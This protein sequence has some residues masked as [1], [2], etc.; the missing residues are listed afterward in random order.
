MKKAILFVL[1]AAMFFLIGYSQ[2]IKTIE[3]KVMIEASDEIVIKTGKSSLIMKKDGTI[4]ITGKDISINGSGTVTAK[5]AGDVIIKG[6]KILE[7]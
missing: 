4:M 6:K 3:R 5:E 2:K 1:L 7:N